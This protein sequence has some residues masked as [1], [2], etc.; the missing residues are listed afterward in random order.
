[1]EN[2]ITYAQLGWMILFAALIGI[3]LFAAMALKNLNQL[4]KGVN[5][6]LEENRAELKRLIPNLAAVSDDAQ[7]ITD[8]VRKLVSEGA[9]AVDQ[10]TESTRE[11]VLKLN[12]TTDHL[13]AYAVIIGEVARVLVD[14]YYDYKKK[15]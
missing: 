5:E 11:T 10:V 7:A 15:K 3:G 4:L 8:D 14:L 9:Q 6:I 2:A 12:R 1:M 13:G